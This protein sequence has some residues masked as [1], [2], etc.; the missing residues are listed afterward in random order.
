M[1]KPTRTR[2]N[3]AIDRRLWNWNSRISPET[4]L[5]NYSLL[6]YLLIAIKATPHNKVEVSPHYILIQ[7]WTFDVTC[8]FSTHINLFMVILLFD[9]N[10]GQTRIGAKFLARKYEYEARTH[11]KLEKFRWKINYGTHKFLESDSDH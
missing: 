3:V 2:G 7:L 9:A 11:V 8:Y 10:C 4:L 5:A 1:K 6:S